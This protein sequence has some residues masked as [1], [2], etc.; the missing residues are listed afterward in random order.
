M[1]TASANTTNANAK[2]NMTIALTKPDTFDGLES[3]AVG[4]MLWKGRPDEIASGLRPRLLAAIN[5]EL[6]LR[7][8]AVKPTSG[9]STDGSSSQG[10]FQLYHGTTVITNEGEFVDALVTIALKA[11]E[12]EIARQAALDP[13]PENDPRIQ[14]YTPGSDI[15]LDRVEDF[16]R[17]NSFIESIKRQ[18][19]DGDARLPWDPLSGNMAIDVYTAMEGQEYERRDPPVM[20]ANADDARCTALVKTMLTDFGADNA[21]STV[22]TNGDS[23]N[24]GFNIVADSDEFRRFAANPNLAASEITGPGKEFAA[25]KLSVEK[26]AALYQKA[27]SNALATFSS[28][29]GYYGFLAQNHV[30]DK[31]MTPEELQAHIKD[32][33]DEILKAQREGYIKREA[34]DFVA[35]YKLDNHGAEPP[36]DKLDAEQARAEATFRGIID[37][38]SAIV[39]RDEIPTPAIVLGDTNWGDPDS[40][41][42]FIAAVD[43]VTGEMRLMKEDKVTRKRS[44]A[45][46]Y[47]KAKWTKIVKK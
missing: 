33:T 12:A 36:A 6:V 43:P 29:L 31:E 21:F 15:P 40:Q 38:K 2:G 28:I 26:A 17:E 39:L 30:P 4:T 27:I 1:A 20:T 24:H 11:A 35:K 5:C 13:I 44:E 18:Y 8:D 37:E 32:Q 47:A 22:A 25:R 16:I 42:M 45:D 23:A 34:G 10:G 14:G 9:R 19:A 7:Y 46:S 3:G 41:V